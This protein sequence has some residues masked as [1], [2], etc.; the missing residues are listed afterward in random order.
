[1]INSVDGDLVSYVARQ[2]AIPQISHII[3]VSPGNINKTFLLQSAEE[4]I[5]LQ[6]INHNVFPEPKHVAENSYRVSHHI[7]KC[8][9]GELRVPEI[10]LSVDR[11]CYVEDTQGG[12]WR[13]QQYVKDTVTYSSIEEQWPAFELGRCLGSFHESVSTLPGEEMHDVLPGFHDLPAYLKLYD[14]VKDKKIEETG[15]KPG[16]QARTAVCHSLIE[17]F[18]SD[19][20]VVDD[21]QHN[22]DMRMRIIHGDP[23]LSNVLFSEKKRKALT[24]IDLDT[25]GGGSILTDI[26]DM[27]RSVAQN[28]KGRYGVTGSIEAALAGYFSISQATELT[29]YEKENIYTALFRISFELG[30]R[31]FTDYLRGNIYFNVEYPEQNVDRALSQFAFVE[32]IE[33]LKETLV[34]TVN[35][36]MK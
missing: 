25:V 26:G 8:H 9:T 35:R 5:I 4:R 14:S 15:Q 12:I 34:E 18:R 21:W 28:S 3:S 13:A 17:H 22:P 32:Y 19:D 36:Q 24:L 27:L 23:K 20:I 30:V 29:E 6:Q 33:T 2:Y 11:R 1:M 31:F 7:N 16:L 10:L